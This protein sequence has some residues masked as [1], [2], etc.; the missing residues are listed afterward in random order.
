MADN[1]DAIS[2]NSDP[3]LDRQGSVLLNRLRAAALADVDNAP[4]ALFHLKVCLVAGVGFFTDAYDIFAINRRPSLS[5]DQSLGLKIATPAGTFFGQLFFGWLADIIGRKRMYGVELVIMIVCTFAQA[6][7]GGGQAVNILST[8]MLWRVL[9]GLGVG[10]DY[11]LSATITSEFAATKIR[12]RMM[13]A[14]FAAQGWGNLAASIVG[15]VITV[16]YRNR[17]NADFPFTP[18]PTDNFV[19]N[20]GACLCNTTLTAIAFA[21]GNHSSVPLC[22]AT[23]T[24][25]NHADYMWRLLIG[26]G[27][28]PA[29][30]ALYFRLTIPETT[31]FMLDIERNVVRAQREIRGALAEQG[32]H[33]VRNGVEVEQRAGAPVATRRDFLRYFGQWDNFCVLFGA[34]WSWFAIDVAFYTLGL[35]ASVILQGAGFGDVGDVGRSLYKL[36]IGNLILSLAGLI[37][38]YWVC[39]FLIDKIG[40]KRIQL[41]GFAVLT[42]LF[43]I[44]GTAFNSLITV[45]AG[46]RV[47]ETPKTKLFILLFCL[48]NFFQNFGPNTTTF[49]IPGEIFPTRYRSTAHG[50]CAAT[51]KLGAIIAQL[52]FFKLVDPVNNPQK[53][54]GHSFEILAGFMFTGLL[55]T[56]LVPETMGQTLEDLSGENQENFMHAPTE[57]IELQ[58]GIVIPRQ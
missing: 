50:I 58:G 54:M 51:G 18:D 40:R 46:Q 27:C 15:T 38:G 14:V 32:A 26:L 36:C 47:D 43:I 33:V 31:R 17:V 42:A 34:A 5:S 52:M 8:L 56:L 24:G 9:T 49:I 48:A 7:A 20:S 13:T 10:G 12:G 16:I 57:A 4:P 2:I 25:I 55:S 35:N 11:P 30:I 44:M 28:V 45:S 39:F 1:D 3:K 23:T 6:T 19:Y 53:F 37:P 29:V 21:S 22:S 41:I